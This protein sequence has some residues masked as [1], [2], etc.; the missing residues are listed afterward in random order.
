MFHT[1]ALGNPERD[2]KSKINAS[3]LRQKFDKLR[4]VKIPWSLKPIDKLFD[5]NLHFAILALVATFSEGYIDRSVAK[6]FMMQGG[7]FLE[8]TIP[9]CLTCFARKI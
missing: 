1:L 7:E 8:F 6:V 2:A 9:A 3:C 5:L 4:L